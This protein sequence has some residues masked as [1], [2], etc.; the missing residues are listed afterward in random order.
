VAE[1]LDIE[2]RIKLDQLRRDF[3]AMED[4]AGKAGAG[5]VKK[6]QAAYI[7][8]EKA[9]A[10]SAK[11][12]GRDWEKSADK[13]SDASERTAEILGE[14]FGDVSDL[15]IDMPK[16]LSEITEGL[17]AVDRALVGVAGG[18]ALVAGAIA[19]VG[20]EAKE[21]FDNIAELAAESEHALRQAGVP[22][23]AIDSLKEYSAASALM[24]SALD[25]LSVTLAAEFAPEMSMA[26]GLVVDLVATLPDA[27]ETTTDWADAWLRVSSLGI[28]DFLRNLKQE[29]IDQN[30]AQLEAIAAWEETERRGRQ[31][32]EQWERLNDQIQ[33]S[34]RDQG[35]LASALENELRPAQ[36][37][38]QDEYDATI[39]RIQK[40]EDTGA[41]TWDTER[42]RTAARLVLLQKQADLEEKQATERERQLKEQLRLAERLAKEQAK[43]E[44]EIAAAFRVAEDA[45]ASLRA[46][47]E[48]SNRELL[49]DE[50]EIQAAYQD[51]I[52]LIHALESAGGDQFAA[53]EAQAAAQAVL[54]RDLAALEQE[55]LDELEKSFSDT[56]GAI[57]DVSRTALGNIGAFWGDLFDDVSN[58]T[59]SIF[60]VASAIGNVAGANTEATAAA[61]VQT[62]ENLQST[63]ED[64]D[65]QITEAS[66][67]QRDLQQQLRD[68]DLTAAERALLE[69]ELA[70]QRALEASLAAERKA[71]QDK[72]RLQEKETD[73]AKEAARQAFGISQ[74]LA[75]A[76]LAIQ[77]GLAVAKSLATLGPPVPPNLPGIAGAAAV[78]AGIATAGIAIATAEAPSFPVGGMASD[79]MLGPEAFGLDFGVRRGDHRLAF[80]EREEGVL[81]PQGVQTAGGPAGVERL[82]SGRATEPPRV[83]VTAV[84]QVD[85]RTLGRLRNTMEPLVSQRSPFP[86]RGR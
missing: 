14:S 74:A 34:K 60:D 24:D 48:A 63:Q 85:G 6:L 83:D 26:L 23:E 73:A 57:E 1:V 27:V 67:A 44:E 52:D 82:N 22:K 75:T 84:L 31:W 4:G 50:G 3:E 69:R 71:T 32:A 7:R 13:I 72:I 56:M 70:Q 79:R 5:M 25:R 54:Q 65:S 29:W 59:G 19:F 2:A 77:G 46:Q 35:A 45:T 33:Q 17:P 42:A 58:I 78:T 20:V 68:E 80:L 36:Q 8:A 47:T 49:D 61:A 21:T 28:V 76:D 9:S 16:R 64:I 55:R 30:S 38:I 66:Q 12:V 40:L 41:S 43:F 37:V 15:L 62:L 51:R 11:K 86:T 18:T 10:R 81:T 53:A 39:K